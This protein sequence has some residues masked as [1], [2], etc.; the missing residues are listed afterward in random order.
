MST[1]TTHEPGKKQLS[2][3]LVGA[4]GDLARRKILPA[5]FAL[6]CQGFLP[7]RFQIIGF[8]RT[9]LSDEAFRTRITEHLTCRY[10][11]GEACKQRMEEF[12]RRCYYV[13][14]QY[15]SRESFVDLY[16]VMRG[17]E[18]AREAN[19]LF[20]MAIPPRLFFDVSKAIGDA[21]LVACGPG[22]AWSR[23]VIEKPFGRDRSTS[24]A[25][26]R[27][28]GQIFSEEQIFRIDHYLGKA[29][30]QNLL[31]LRFA[32]TL[33]EPTWNRR[34]IS[35]VEI[36]W[37]EGIGVEGRGG[38]FDEY[39]IIRDVVQ[40]HLLQIL[41]LVA[42]EPPR[43]VDARHVRDEKVKVLR[44]IPPV[45]LADLLVGQYQQTTA[46]GVT[47]PSYTDEESVPNDSRTAT[48]AAAVLRI[49]NER[50]QGV[51]FLVQAGKGLDEK[52]TEV[53]IYF[54][55]AEGGIFCGEESCPPKNQLV[56]RIQP[57]EAIA[58]RVVNKVPDLG[59]RL[60]QAELELPYASAFGDDIPEAYECLLLD[61]LEGDK[62]LFI[63]SDE[64]EAAWD[65]VTPVLHEMDD[66]GIQPVPYAFGAMGPE[67]IQAMADRCGIELAN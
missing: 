55:P 43:R 41:A 67:G 20:Y 8:A 12:L 48:Y 56:I 54:R 53:R 51:P 66:S 10:G 21:G 6:H 32:N 13:S 14:G 46:G 61:V 23:A 24:D 30:V 25:L 17:L 40:N 3:V 9:P 31:V 4:S 22:P 59:M 35:A 49:E 2:V 57:D 58:L 37:K 34:Y 47:H 7:E 60:S 1:K 15:G 64:L 62:S 36:V 45:G 52:L 44:A 63:R 65:V 19:R 28:M 5:L 26:A 39:G 16:A 29:L 27:S 42:M 50:W 18:G 33:F 11:P 38:Y